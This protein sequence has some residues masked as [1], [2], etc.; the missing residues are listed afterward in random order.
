MNEVD[1]SVEGLPAPDWLPA[2]GDFAAAVLEELGIRGWEVSIL[3]CTDPFIQ[4]LNRKYRGVAAPTDVL[5]FPQQ[6]PASSGREPGAPPAGN[7]AAGDIVISLETLAR[8]AGREGED[9]QTELKRLLIHGIL[10]LQGLDHPEEGQSP[11]LATQEM[12]LERLRDKRVG[13]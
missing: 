11:M 13:P 12:L 6:Q 2:C 9:P 10:H 5:S 4:E 3:L 1:V 8:N 7:L